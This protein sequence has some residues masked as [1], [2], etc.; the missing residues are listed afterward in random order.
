MYTYLRKAFRHFT[1]GEGIPSVHCTCQKSNHGRPSV[2]WYFSAVGYLSSWYIKELH[3]VYAQLLLV[4]YWKR[5]NITKHAIGGTNALGKQEINT[6]D[7]RNMRFRYPRF[8][9]SAILFQYHE[10]HQ[11][12][13][14]G[15][16]RTC[17]AGP[18]S[19]ARSFTDSPHH[20]DSGYYKS[21]PVM[22]H[23]SENTCA[24]FCILF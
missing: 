10:E 3:S 24:C 6:S 13:I 16:G 9:N 21:R 22:V 23:H 5:D 17:R 19:C 20:F 7:S 18:L 1:S 15:H 11:Y 14:R 12:P 4:Q 8:R 2:A